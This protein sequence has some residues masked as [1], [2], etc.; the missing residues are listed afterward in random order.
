MALEPFVGSCQL[1]QFLNSGGFLGRGISPSQGRNLHTDIH[2]LS[3]IRTHNPSFRATEDN[4]C[5][6]PRGNCDW[7]FNIVQQQNNIIP[8]CVCIRMSD[9]ISHVYWQLKYRVNSCGG[10]GFAQ[11]LFRMGSR[12][13]HLPVKPVKNY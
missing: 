6:R 5:P 8:F 9:V 11:D 10:C 12:L 7:P 4:S 3:G 1:S 13:I 2:V